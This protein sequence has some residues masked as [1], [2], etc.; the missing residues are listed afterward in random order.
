[1][2]EGERVLTDLAAWTQINMIE[3]SN[4]YID[5]APSQS[6]SA[7]QDP[8]PLAL[9]PAATFGGL[10]VPVVDAQLF[11]AL[12]NVIEL[13]RSKG[14]QV[15]C[16]LVPLYVGPA[17]LSSMAC[18][19]ITGSRVPGPHPR[20]ALYGCPNNPQ[21]AR[22]A[23]EMAREFVERWPLDVLTF[24][25]FEYPPWPHHGLRHL[26]TGFTSACRR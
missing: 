16:N 2:N 12:Q 26:F 6:N 19:D 25:H 21:V 14:F 18:V 9:P 22:Y 4:F 8:A 11:G 13:I 24:N 3:L 20:L 17:E 1:L 7:S 15:A 5:W 23:E 10:S